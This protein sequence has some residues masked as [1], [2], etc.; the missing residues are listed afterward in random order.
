MVK[1]VIPVMDEA[2]EWISA[3]FGRAP[4]FA[5]FHLEDGKVLEKGIVPNDS[6]HF[7]GIG[8]PPERIGRLGPDAVISPGMGMRA[9]NMFQDMG[10]AVLQAKRE[11]S[12]E[13][14]DLFMK[15]ELTEL[16]E[17]CLHARHR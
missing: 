3:H 7:G 6:E 2:G 12:E 15:G 9:I 16:T 17:G 8:R 14:L 4:F 13:N 11:R 10:V 5:W 1:I